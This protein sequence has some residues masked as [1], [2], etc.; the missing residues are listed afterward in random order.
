MTEIEVPL[1]KVQEDLIEH[2]HHSGGDRLM[3]RLA[4][5][6][7]LLAALAA[8][9]A[10]LAGHHA[11]EAML[12]QIHA[13]DQWSYFQAKGIKAA[14]LGTK[15][16]L[17]RVLGKAPAGKDVEKLAEYKKEQEEIKKDAEEKEK[18]SRAHLAHHVILARAVTMFQVAIAIAAICALTHRRRF[19]FVSLGFG[20]AGI[21]FLAQG[22]L[23]T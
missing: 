2:A 13:S 17:T 1:D 21:L 20:I 3:M 15:L 14:V 18:E 9:A 12:E 19:L 22:I 11:N 16:D 5:T 10:L 4:L 8:V 7:A 6:S 23:V